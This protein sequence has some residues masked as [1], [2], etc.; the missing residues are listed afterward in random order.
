[1]DLAF[2]MIIWYTT[3]ASSLPAKN[4]RPYIF[5]HKLSSTWHTPTTPRP[6]LL[7]ISIQTN[8][9]V[10]Y[11][12]KYSQPV[13]N[14]NKVLTRCPTSQRPLRR[15]PVGE[16]QLQEFWSL[17][18]NLFRGTKWQKGQ[19]NSKSIPI[20]I[21]GLFW[22]RVNPRIMQAGGESD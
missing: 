21:L 5:T 15:G 3:H 8:N 19:I 1:M 12:Y 4:C 18:F 16:N 20:Q 11:R 7:R 13:A 2:I 17:T 22:F 10:P 14:C 9:L 6:P